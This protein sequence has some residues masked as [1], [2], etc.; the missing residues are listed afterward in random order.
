MGKAKSPAEILQEQ[1][2]EGRPAKR[3]KALPK[4]LRGS[5][6]LTSVIDTSILDDDHDQWESRDDRDRELEVLLCGLSGGARKEL[7]AAV[8]PKLA[9]AMERAW[10]D[11]DRRPVGL[12]QYGEVC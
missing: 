5:K 11:Q 2:V 6:A 3:I 1:A 9:V 4:G 7:F 12:G 10:R 8:F